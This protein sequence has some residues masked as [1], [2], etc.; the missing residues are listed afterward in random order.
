[1]KKPE[2]ITLT[3][4]PDGSTS[5]S[6]VGVDGPACT[7]LTKEVVGAVGET[8]DVRHTEEFHRRVQPDNRQTLGRS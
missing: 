4:N 7:A 6:V 3:I 1:M 2:L 8:Q 5:V